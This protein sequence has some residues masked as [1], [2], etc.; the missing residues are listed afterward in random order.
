LGSKINAIHMK[1][2]ILITGAAG[3][4]G[5][6]VTARFLQEGYQVFAITEPGKPKQIER[7]QQAAGAAADL[8]IAAIDA[9]D[10]QAVEDY[11]RNHFQAAPLHAA[12]LL[13]GGFAQGDISS[14]D[15]QALDQMIQLNFKT[16]FFF[17][18]RCLPRM[19][20]DGRFFLIGARPALEPQSAGDLAAYALAK[21]MVVQLAAIINARKNHQGVQ[22]A[23][24]LPSIIDTP[25]NREA[26]PDADFSQ[27]VKPTEI[28]QTMAYACSEAG[29]KQRQPVFKLYGGA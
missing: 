26:M 18:R 15:E 17:A 27:W 19:A 16:A 23:L 14:T 10:E 2:R 8:H 11:V 29:L 13:I 9:M 24:I 28:A 1:K 7:L 12:A 5:L 20:A 22:A 4:L 21:G 25:A 3:G 6:A